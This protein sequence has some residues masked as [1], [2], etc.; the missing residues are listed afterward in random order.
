MLHGG[1]GDSPARAVLT[2]RSVVVCCGVALLG[3]GHPIKY[4]YR[5]PKYAYRYPKYA[6]RYPKYAYRYPKYAYRYP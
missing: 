3:R 2:R 1:V 6:Y 5:Y 4:A